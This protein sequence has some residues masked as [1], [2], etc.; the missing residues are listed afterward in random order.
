MHVLP[1]PQCMF[2]RTA[3]TR[4]PVPARR[5]VDSL[6]GKARKAAGDG[7]PIVGECA[8]EQMLGQM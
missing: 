4:V 3:G 5:R 7:I 8:F 6:S 2:C 1:M